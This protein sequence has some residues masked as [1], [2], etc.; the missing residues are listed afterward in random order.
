MIGK[1]MHR[2][3]KM[4]RRRRK[5]VI[6]GNLCVSIIGNTCI[7][8]Q[9]KQCRCERGGCNALGWNH[10]GSALCWKQLCNA[11][12]RK[13]IGLALCWERH[14]THKYNLASP[15]ASAKI[16]LA[17][18]DRTSILDVVVRQSTVVLERRVTVDKIL[19]PAVN[20][21]D[22]RDQR[23]QGLDRVVRHSF[24][25][26][27]IARGCLHVDMHASRC[28][29]YGHMHM[30][31]TYTQHTAQKQPASG[32]GNVMR[33]APASCGGCSSSPQKPRGPWRRRCRPRRWRGQWRRCR[34]C[35]LEVAYMHTDTRKHAHMHTNTKTHASKDQEA[36]SLWRN[37]WL[38][39]TGQ[40]IALVSTCWERHC[41]DVSAPYKSYMSFACITF[42]ILLHWYQIQIYA[43]IK[44][45]KTVIFNI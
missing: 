23:L 27:R 6:P 32:G 24:E 4:Q 41:N 33:R 21:R 36:P 22:V 29:Q 25:R 44:Y 39:C 19:S 9:Q 2:T 35:N 16:D 37:A 15:L 45:S 8:G 31:H 11:L 42:H 5:P 40:N 26:D 18:D 30:I 43:L 34:R 28:A 38:H 12:G 13:H 17:H 1:S 3:I 20:L 14:N 7:E 10:I